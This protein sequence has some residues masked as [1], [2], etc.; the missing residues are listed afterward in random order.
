MVEKS[1]KTATSTAT[2]LDVPAL[3]AQAALDTTLR[4]SDKRALASAPRGLLV[5]VV[6][7]E[8]WVP[9]LRRTLVAL[10]PGA[11]V[12]E[13]TEVRR[14]GTPRL[15]A[16]EIAEKVAGGAQVVIV[17]HAPTR[18]VPLE[19]RA[20]A[21]RTITIEGVSVTVVRRLLH[22]VTGQRGRTLAA[23]DLAGL[24]FTDVVA[25]VRAGAS[26]SD[27]VARLRRARMY[28]APVAP[29]TPH[30]DDLVGY[31]KAF[32]WAQEMVED[33]RRVSA[34]EAIPLESALIC[35]PPGTG[36]TRLA[37]SIAHSA[38]VPW[39]SA[40]IADFFS[41]GEGS[42]GDVVQ[43]MQ[44]FF[45][46]AAAHRPCVVV[47]DEID[48]L[49]SRMGMTRRG[50][51][52]WSTAVNGLLVEIDRLRA[53]QPPVLLLAITNHAA[54]LDPAL[55]RPGRL[56]RRI[57]IDPPD[58][59]SL[60]AVFRVV[61]G[62]CNI[63]LSGAELARV[64]ALGRGATGAQVDAWV[65]A[66][67]GRARRE[68]RSATAADLEAEIL[69]RAMLSDRDRRT[70]ALHEAGHVIVARAHG[71]RVDRVVL[72]G[73][74]GIAGTTAVAVCEGYPTRAVVEADLAI[75]LGGR[76]A[77][78]I[79]GDGA[80]GGAVAD[81]AAATRLAA[82]ARGALGLHDRLAFLGDPDE[83]VQAVRRDPGLAEAVEADLGAAL[84]RARTIVTA[85]AADVLRLADRLMTR[86][87]LLGAEI[88]AVISNRAADNGIPCLP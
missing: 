18:C 80:N 58:G 31:G 39:V 64:S 53:H 26:A 33:I 11:T 76:A 88:E 2:T 10:A 40:S 22:R 30:V 68:G 38:G 54:R 66:A 55:T 42:L 9:P 77:D 79:L 8:P 41:R 27:A 19:I 37:R 73:G 45:S 29:D 61:A 49:P 50:H 15:D 59:E 85:Q 78:D 35:G 72:E 7:S 21:D 44:R 83:V 1:P 86:Q 43:A 63:R 23:A 47:L 74:D 81:L 4:P 71:R 48:A 24:D 69:P 51:E 20:A 28:C 34:G 17:S 13:A 75:I 36:K 82:S 14:D 5:I 87:V 57:D 84:D 46:Q 67:E 52:W 6:P 70:A 25:A 12:V 16:A 3:L 32:V 56:D 60:A 65:R 62:A